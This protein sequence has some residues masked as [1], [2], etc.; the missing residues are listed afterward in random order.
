MS[1]LNQLFNRGVLG[2]KCKTCLT[3]VISRMKLIQNKRDVNLKLMR[4]EIAQFLQ[5][6]QEA[7]ARIRV[8][9]VIREQNIQAAYDILELF[10]EFVLARVPVLE[11][12]KECPTELREAIASIVFA[13]PRC[14]DLP[15]LM[16][17]RNLFGAKYGKEFVMAAS[18]LRPDT[19][20][21]RSLIERLS[22]NAPSAEARLELLKQIAREYNLNW[23]SSN[24]EAEFRKNHEDLLGGTKQISVAPSPS[25]APIKLGEPKPSNNGVHKALPSNG[26]QGTRQIPP[27]SRN[28]SLSK[29]N[30]IQP[31]VNH[32][33]TEPINEIRIEPKP[34]PSEVLDM[35]QA[36]IASAERACAAARAAAALVNVK[37]VSHN[38][39]LQE[40]KSS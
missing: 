27:P 7:I 14:S 39:N 12:Q 37:Y 31:S 11:S 38:N 1:L 29:A 25:E 8:E 26:S 10:C 3:L 5:T 32:T 22:V 33:P 6:G 21:N 34:R 24:T 40:A 17:I 18:E 20:V 13:A 19:S 36:A 30:E 28:A 15:D 23:D 16:Q 4:K 2:A 35:A 9:H